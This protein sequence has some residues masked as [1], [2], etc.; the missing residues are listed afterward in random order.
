MI[1]DVLIDCVVSVAL[2]QSLV[3]CV[4]VLMFFQITHL[5]HLVNALFLTA[6]SVFPLLTADKVHFINMT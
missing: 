1:Y 4:E 5:F 3:T 2:I 6:E